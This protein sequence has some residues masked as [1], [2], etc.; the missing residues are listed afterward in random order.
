ML[1]VM[2]TRA[3]GILAVVALT[4]CPAVMKQLG[5]PGGVQ[6]PPPPRIVVAEVRLARM[7]SKENIARY[8]CP[9][10]A[11]TPFLCQALGRSP[12]A[13]ELAFV[14][15]LRLD[16][17][18]SAS[19]PLPMVEALTAFT[20]FPAEQGAQ[21]LG[22][23]CLAMCDDPATCPPPG[24]DACTGGGPSIKTKEDFAMAAASFLVNV[25]AGQA[26]LDNLR[27]KTIPAG[28]T[29][30]VVIQLQL[31]PVQ[32]LGLVNR[33]AQDAIAQVKRGKVPSFT[34]PYSVEGSVWVRVEG[35][36]KLSAAFGPYANQ[37][38]L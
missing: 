22:A 19:I 23:V 13:A 8:L 21:N 27:I 2:S 20:A 24:A 11:P 29:T 3:L 28:A 4:G 15:E 38:T 17:T 36:G 33:F 31:D 34:I 37:W 30:Q 35:F 16:V 14:F 6:A 10:V 1:A 5:G 25:A 9:Q 32:L 7:P 12:T 18:N 26:S